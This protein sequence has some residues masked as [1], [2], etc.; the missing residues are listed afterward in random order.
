L[1][2]TEP[3]EDT[4]QPLEEFASGERLSVVGDR[5]PEDG[6]ILGSDTYLPVRTQSEK[7]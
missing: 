3:Y 2:G 5:C 6:K 4:I 1:P 7:P